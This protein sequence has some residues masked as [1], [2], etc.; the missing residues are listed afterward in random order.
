MKSKEKIILIITILTTLITI[1]ILYNIY[2]NQTTSYATTPNVAEVEISNAEK[3]EIENYLQENQKENFE[4]IITEEV[5]LEYITQYK[6]NSSLPKGTI[7][8]LQEGRTGRQQITTQ[9]TYNES[10][11]IIKEEQINSIVIKSAVNKIVEIGTS[12][13]IKV[14]KITKGT[15]IYVTSDRAEIMQENSM[16]STK[17]T[18]ITKKQESKPIEN[19][20][21]FDENGNFIN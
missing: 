11:E 1:Y 19:K 14:S 8:V 10:G 17:I 3:V 20:D 4:E 5:E 15:N 13:T 16:Q 12:N 6:N 18:T 21:I 9:R 2:I 7:Q